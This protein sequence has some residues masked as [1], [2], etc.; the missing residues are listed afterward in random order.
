MIKLYHKKNEVNID[1]SG[2]G[3][4]RAID[5]SYSGKIFAESQ[6]PDSWQLIANSNRIMCLSFGGSNPDSLFHYSGLMQIRGVTVID[7]DLN[8]HSA[9]IIIQDIDYWQNITGKFDEDA[10]FWDR[11]GSIHQGEKG[12]SGTS[13]V[14][15]NLLTNS[16][17]FYFEDGMP[18]DGEYHQHQ[19]GQAM[20]GAE[21]SDDSENIYRKTQDGKIYNPR[22]KIMKRDII[23]IQD[24]YSKILKAKEVYQPRIGTP[25]STEGGGYTGGGSD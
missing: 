4:V 15:N 24:K 14:K 12:L 16:D 17:E 13:I 5:I 2:I 18:Y 21:H 25:P 3:I 6:L 9:S 8:K 19:D 20:T 1:L 11:L 7:S 10:Q 23:K 22:K